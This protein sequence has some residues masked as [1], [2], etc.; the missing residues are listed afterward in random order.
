MENIFKALSKEYNAVKDKQ[1]EDLI[2]K[3]ELLVEVVDYVNSMK[4]LSRTP[5][6]KKITFFI[7]SG[8]D[9]EALCTEFDISYESA[10][11]SVKW[12][13]KQLKSKIGVH[14]VKLIR[15]GYISEARD[16]FY[17]GTGQISRDN[18]FLSDI[19]RVLPESKFSAA[20]DLQDC[21]SELEFL[22]KISLD[23]IKKLTKKVDKSKLAYL[24]SLIEGSSRKATWLRPYI[25][26]MLMGYMKIEELLVMEEKIKEE[27]NIY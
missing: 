11:N 5:V 4:W 24:L 13:S 20:Y 23:Y 3:K 27:K 18:L 1:D 9:Y 12:A 14:T 16:A 15:D 25:I 21:L 10:K 26:D 19:A 6:K 22:R 7:K 8:Y 17:V 2:E